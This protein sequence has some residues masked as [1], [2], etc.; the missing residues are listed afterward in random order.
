MKRWIARQSSRSHLP[1]LLTQWRPAIKTYA[2]QE[3]KSRRQARR[4]SIDEGLDRLAD[5][6]EMGDISQRT[7]AKSSMLRSIRRASVPAESFTVLS[8]VAPYAD[9]GLDFWSC[10]ELARDFERRRVQGATAG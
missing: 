4:R 1:T 8:S 9:T 6:F 2:G 3:R 7:T 5:L 10:A